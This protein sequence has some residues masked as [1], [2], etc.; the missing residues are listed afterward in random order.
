MRSL[1]IAAA[2][3]AL[4][5]GL[6]P[7]GTAQAAR[8]YNPAIQAPSLVEDVACRTVRERVVRPGGAVVYRTKRMCGP[9]PFAR[10][11]DCRMVRS[12]IVRPNGAVVYRTVR[13]CR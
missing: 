9:G 6:I 10:G 13:R 3:A 8:F 7:A 12:K 11:R 5:I 1:T 4:S 2:L